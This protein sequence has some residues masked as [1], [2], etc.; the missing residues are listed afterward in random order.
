VTGLVAF[1]RARLDEDETAAKQAAGE[2]PAPWAEDYGD[3]KAA[4]GELIV[5]GVGYGGAA[6]HLYAV[7]HIAR[8]DPARVLREVEA[9]RAILDLYE[10]AAIH[11]DTSLGV[12]TLRTV[13]K[14]LAAV[15]RDHPDFDPAGTITDR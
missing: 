13:V 15:Y 7:E 11:D 3:L 1:L 5:D 8:H 10:A 9:K 14:A 4:D 6:W 12:A 2:S